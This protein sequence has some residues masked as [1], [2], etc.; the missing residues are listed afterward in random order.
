MALSGLYLI[1]RSCEVSRTLES[2]L[3]IDDPPKYDYSIASRVEIASLSMYHP[4]E[5]SWIAPSLLPRLRKNAGPAELGR[6]TTTVEAKLGRT[7]VVSAESSIPTIPPKAGGW[8]LILR[9]TLREYP[10]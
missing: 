10:F 1:F 5:T 2:I 7:R 9:Y 8:S 4:E 3:N 6:I